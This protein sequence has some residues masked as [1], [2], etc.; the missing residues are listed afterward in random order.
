MPVSGHMFFNL[1]PEIYLPKPEKIWIKPENSEN[2]R[3]RPQR[4]VFPKNGVFGILVFHIDTITLIIQDQP[5]NGRKMTAETE[6]NN[7]ETAMDAEEQREHLKPP[8]QQMLNIR[9]CHHRM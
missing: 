2:S 1:Q 8:T 5:G 3:T 4:S 7:A 6:N 9:I